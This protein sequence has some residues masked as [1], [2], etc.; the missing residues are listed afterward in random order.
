MLCMK[1]L[2]CSYIRNRYHRVSTF[3]KK[4]EEEWSRHHYG[5]FTAFADFDILIYYTTINYFI[6][7]YWMSTSFLRGIYHIPDR[8]LERFWSLVSL[9]EINLHHFSLVT[10]EMTVNYR[11]KLPRE[12][13]HAKHQNLREFFNLRKKIFDLCFKFFLM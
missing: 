13:F 10:M 3:V 4:S 6:I 12:D 7:F 5:R 2:R 9:I 8:I 1:K 11:L